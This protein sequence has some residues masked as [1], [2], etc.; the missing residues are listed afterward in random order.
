MKQACVCVLAYNEQNHIA[1]T[2]QAIRAGNDGVDFDVV[3]YA[4]GCTDQTTE[5][6]KGLLA[7]VPNL[8]LRELAK[9]SKPEAWN[10]AFVENQNLVLFFS[11]GDIAPEPGCVARL[12]QCLTENPTV[13]IVCPELRPQPTGLPLDKRLTGFLQI[14]FAQDFLNGAFYAVRR[15]VIE[16]ALKE[17]ELDGI[18]SG[19]VG[20]DAF[21]Q[22]LVPRTAF[23]VT[24]QRVFYEP[25]ALSDYYKYLARIRWQNEQLAYYRDELGDPVRKKSSTVQRLREK[26]SATRRF[27][28]LIEGAMSTATRRIV[29]AAN[30]RRID[31]LYRKLGPVRRE[32]QEILGS[33]TRSI[34]TK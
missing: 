3:V 4:N 11:D 8:R 13:S 30:R 20:E 7:T 33:S 27:T 16:R 22:T 28:R 19:I 24:E 1:R 17:R 32:G 12:Y 18:P 26:L 6:V 5:V 15:D 31:N 23:R 29:T 2:V 25:P 21:V 34:S 10:T 14:P 9:P